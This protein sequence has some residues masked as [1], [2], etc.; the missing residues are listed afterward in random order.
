MRPERRI[1]SKKTDFAKVILFLSHF[2]DSCQHKKREEEKVFLSKKVFL[3]LYKGRLTPTKVF[4]DPVFLESQI[5]FLLDFWWKRVKNPPYTNK[6]MSKKV[7]FCFFPLFGG[8]KK[9][10]S[11]PKKCFQI[12]NRKKCFSTAV[13]DT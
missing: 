7:L 5:C 4:F 9:T 6:N 11:Q 3:F 1:I 12:L 10:N 8:P 2:F 13:D